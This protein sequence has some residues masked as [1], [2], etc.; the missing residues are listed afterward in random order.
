MVPI[1]KPRL[2][3][4][5]LTVEDHSIWLRLFGGYLPDRGHD[6]RL[7]YHSTNA[8][9]RDA[10]LM[11]GA[12]AARVGRWGPLMHWSPER[13]DYTYEYIWFGGALPSSVAIDPQAAGHITYFA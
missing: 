6:I 5:P 4:A 12:I 9:R 8:D 13:S 3:S 1:V 10:D 11:C 2:E 7:R